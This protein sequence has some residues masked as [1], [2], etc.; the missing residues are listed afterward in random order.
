VVERFAGENPNEV[1][2]KMTIRGP[3]LASSALAMVRGRVVGCVFEMGLRGRY[4]K[5]ASFLPA[6]ISA[7]FST[8]PIQ[9]VDRVDNLFHPIIVRLPFPHPAPPPH[10][11]VPHLGNDPHIWQ[12][13][14]P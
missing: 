6:L 14:I 11:A 4:P 1:D 9:L 5:T 13:R 2:R 8:W 3:K 7:T 12:Q 10:L